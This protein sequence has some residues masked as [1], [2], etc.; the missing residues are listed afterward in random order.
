MKKYIKHTKG[1]LLLLID[2]KQAFD[3]AQLEG[4]WHIQLY[5]GVPK[6]MIFSIK[7]MCSK[8]N[9]QVQAPRE[10]NIIFLRQQM[11]SLIYTSF[12]YIP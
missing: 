9:G 11:F 8:L 3:L 12:Q 6:N 10:T 5:Y 4:L 7:D 1:L 2:F